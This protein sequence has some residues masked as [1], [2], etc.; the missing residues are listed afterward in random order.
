MRLSK[1]S[2][3]AS[4]SVLPGFQA[5][6]I[7]FTKGREGG[8]EGGEA[9]KCLHSTPTGEEH[10]MTRNEVLYNYREILVLKA[11]STYSAFVP[12]RQQPSYVH[13]TST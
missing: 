2:I 7:I 1:K 12:I 11:L 13:T 3:K 9:S 5:L 4:N 8:R 6:N 10:N